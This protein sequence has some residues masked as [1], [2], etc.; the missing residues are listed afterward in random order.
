MLTADYYC[1]YIVLIYYL[2]YTNICQYMCT[3]LAY[4]LYH[5]SPELV[6]SDFQLYVELYV[7][8]PIENI[9]KSPSTPVKVFKKLKKVCDIV[10]GYSPYCFIL[11]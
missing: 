8:H 10:C 1:H 6:T 7:S 11:V 2:L 3:A 4:F 9:S 5:F